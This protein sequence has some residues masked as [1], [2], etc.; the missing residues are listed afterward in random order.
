VTQLDS[1]SFGHPPTEQPPRL[2][3]AKLNAFI[4]KAVDDWGS[5]TSAALVDIRDR[6]SLYEALADAGP[7]STRRS[8][9]AHWYRLRLHSTLAHQSRKLQPG[10][11][12]NAAASVLMCTPHGA[13]EGGPAL[14]TIATDT[15]L[16]EVAGAAGLPT[17]AAKTSFNRVFEARR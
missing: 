4:A 12:I 15:A 17:C 2:D 16:P 6:F 14:G 9:H 8:R 13:S 1:S 11:R 3:Q 5:L 7:A 10:G